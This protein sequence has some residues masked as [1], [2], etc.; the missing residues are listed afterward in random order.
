MCSLVCLHSSL[1][2]PLL[3]LPCKPF[4]ANTADVTPRLRSTHHYEHPT[5]RM[6]RYRHFL[7]PP[8][9]LPSPLSSPY[10]KAIIFSLTL[11]DEADVRRPGSLRKHTSRICLFHLSGFC[12]LCFWKQ[13]VL[14]CTAA[15]SSKILFSLGKFFLPILS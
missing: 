2:N 1:S 3:C 15:N 10:S 9:T 14:C 12:L 7:Q 11:R 5:A 6:L 4:I 13:S 8:P